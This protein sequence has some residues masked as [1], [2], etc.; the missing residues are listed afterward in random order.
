MILHQWIGTFT[1][2]LWIFVGAYL[3]WMGE[4]IGWQ[5]AGGIAVAL[6]FLRAIG[7]VMGLRGMKQ[8]PSEKKP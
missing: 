2:L 6:G 3:I 1:A 8:S 4:S 7:V 5:I